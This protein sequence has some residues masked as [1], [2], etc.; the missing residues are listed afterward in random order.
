MLV[1][2]EEIR[3]RVNA[4]LVKK[5]NERSQ[6]PSNQTEDVYFRGVSD[7]YRQIITMF[8]EMIGPSGA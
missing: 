7:G 3:N 2:A 6:S 8:D 4:Q 5:L 1:N